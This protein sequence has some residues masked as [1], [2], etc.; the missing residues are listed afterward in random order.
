[1]MNILRMRT[2]LSPGWPHGPGAQQTHPVFR[3]GVIL[4]KTVWRTRRAGH[5][6]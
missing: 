4:V 2:P 6:G 3:P 1:M 5:C